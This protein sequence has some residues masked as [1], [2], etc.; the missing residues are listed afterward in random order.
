M[1]RVVVIGDGAMGILCAKMLAGKGC[2]VVL[3]S[4]FPQQA[5]ELKS[6]RASRFLPGV[7]LPEPVQVTTEAQE[8]F[9]GADLAISAVPAQFVRQVWTRLRGHCPRGLPVCST[10]KGIENGTLLRPTCVLAEVLTGQPDGAWPLAALSG[11]CIAYE[12]ARELPATVVA[13]STDQG[14]AERVQRLFSASYFRVYTNADLV[15][16]EVG[17]AT[18]NVIAIAAGILDGLGAGD[19]AKAALVTRGLVEITRLGVAF[20][21]R[22]ETFFGLA[23]LGDLVVTCFSPHGRNRTFGQALGRGGTV[24]EA[25]AATPGVVEGA[26]TTASVVELASRQAVEMPITQAVHAVLFLG[27]HPSRAV[28]GLMSRPPKREDQSAP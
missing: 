8:A 27:Q 20:G 16:V 1:E 2:A 3:W 14:L 12:V 13:A 26:A 6:T 23:G 15:G 22:R 24:P 18:K 28:A 9:A 4:A 7:L 21:G 17:G 10:T 5:A 11:P 19:N 25:L